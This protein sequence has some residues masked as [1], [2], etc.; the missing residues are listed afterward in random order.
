MN[1]VIRNDAAKSIRAFQKFGVPALKQIFGGDAQIHSYEGSN[2]PV[3][4]ELDLNHGIDGVIVDGEGWA[5]NYA[6]R[7]QFLKYGGLSFNTFTIRT[8]RP[9]GAKTE[10]DKMQAVDEPTSAIHV[11]T[12]V[13]GDGRGAVVGIAGTAE[14]KQAV[15]RYKPETKYNRSDNVGF[16]AID[17]YKVEG[18]RVFYVD[19]SGNTHKF[20]PDN[21]VAVI[22]DGA[23]GNTWRGTTPEEADLM[24]KGIAQVQI[25]ETGIAV[26]QIVDP[27]PV[28][29]NTFASEIVLPSYERMDDVA[30]LKVF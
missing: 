16:A 17:F 13:D 24:G 9:S 27:H 28:N 25:V 18:V 11:Q 29:L 1:F 21:Y 22:P 4:R 2:D 15:Y 20:V 23:L 7:V 5:H 6:S 3:E 8:R 19:E 30:L 10:I 14:V 12:Y 26:T